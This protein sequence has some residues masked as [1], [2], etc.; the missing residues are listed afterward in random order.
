MPEFTKSVL[1]LSNSSDTMQPISE[2]FE[3]RGFNAIFSGFNVQELSQ[4]P[5]IA[6]NVI[7]ISVNNESPN[8]EPI[9]ARIKSHYIGIGIPVLALLESTPPMK[10]SYIDSILLAPSHPVQIV[11]RAIALMRLAVMEQE[12]GLRLETLEN[13]F[14][15][16]PSLPRREHKKR[17]DILFIGKASPEFMV[18]INALQKENVSVTAA[19]T[20]FT[21]FDYLYEKTF[22][23]IVMNGL[24]STEPAYSVIE[25]MR[26]NAKLYHVPAMLL[27]DSKTFADHDAAYSLGINDVIDADSQLSD[28]SSRILEQAN[29]HRTHK[30]LKDDFSTIG[31]EACIDQST[32]LFNRAFFNAH[33]S[34]MFKLY[35][36]LNMPISLC[37]IRVRYDKQIAANS[38]DLEPAYGQIG[39][40]IKN[41]VRL[42]DTSARL[43]S[44]LFAI[45]FPGQTTEQLRVVAERISS[46]L[47]CAT[48]TDFETGQKLEL[49]LDI[50]LNTLYD[51]E[52]SQS[53][54]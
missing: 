42:Q 53:I 7:V 31:G 38:P 29:F 35:N 19:F 5:T 15:A 30:N 50:T 48:L 26:K 44:N 36:R 23:A 12:I 18:I 25:T 45:A 1:L 37:L 32:G 3:A 6:P 41:L 2:A 11:L 47:K 20:S 46:I 52:I 27:I 10:I 39:V 43:D 28:I 54:A 16:S 13:N 24:S 33:V 14:R 8:L 51:E 9:I 40:M 34:R 49:S 21:A 17:F 4:L 22:D